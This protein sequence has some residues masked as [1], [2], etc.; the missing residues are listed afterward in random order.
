MKSIEK[1][2]VNDIAPKINFFYKGDLSLL[3]DELN[4]AY[5][6]AQ[7]NSVFSEKIDIIVK[8]VDEAKLQ[9]QGFYF[10]GD[11]SLLVEQIL[12]LNPEEEVVFVEETAKKNSNIIDFMPFSKLSKVK[13]K[14]VDKVEPEI[15]IIV[16]IFH[17]QSRQCVESII[18]NTTEPYR[19]TLAMNRFV[20]N[21]IKGANFFGKA[22]LVICE[23]GNYATLL[24]N[25]AIKVLF[26]ED[27]FKSCPTI[28]FIAEN[29]EVKLGWDKALLVQLVNRKGL[30]TYSVFVGDNSEVR[31][32][33]FKVVAIKKEVIQE[34]GLLNPNYLEVFFDTAYCMRAYDFGWEIGVSD[35]AL[36][37]TFHIPRN[38][39]QL[40]L[41]EAGDRDRFG[42][43][44][45]SVGWLPR[46]QEFLS[47]LETVVKEEEIIEV[48]PVYEGPTISLDESLPK[49]SHPSVGNVY[50]YMEEKI[51]N[52]TKLD[53]QSWFKQIESVLPYCRGKGIDVGSGGRTLSKETFRV[54][55]SEAVA[56]HLIWDSSTLPMFA[57]NSV[58]FIFSNQHLEHIENTLQA[59][60][61]WVR[62]VK[63]G[64]Y[65][66]IIT[67]DR[68]AYGAPGS[69]GTDPD[70]KHCW[71]KQEFWEMIQAWVSN[72]D[73]SSTIEKEVDLGSDYGVVLKKI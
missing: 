73:L 44:F 67:I 19:L 13:S 52:S 57:D 47:F 64:G 48:K 36:V 25:A 58:D 14:I 50:F 30:A 43:Q 26:T 24:F 71:R 40:R 55:K 28:I 1:D 3:V 8:N 70:H 6:V 45:S 41:A 29:V 10:S 59:L 16:P 65:V 61:E 2:L 69:K 15:E 35:L 42:K 63:P 62:V 12:F 17:G 23:K 11:L 39:E 46:R 53:Y 31:E 21:Q 5:L 22:N 9:G 18:K 51:F 60:Q 32:I 49:I 56:P 38:E 37:S 7:D 68:D 33:P 66:N 20:Y 27:N 72:K 34:I 4:L 54:D